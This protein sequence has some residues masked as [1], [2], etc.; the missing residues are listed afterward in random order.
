MYTA[1]RNGTG[2]AVY[3]P[4][5]DQNSPDRLALVG[6]LRR[7]IDE[8]E[9]VLHYQP[10]LDIRTNQVVGVEAL[11][12]W[13]HPE[14]GVLSPGEFIGVAEETG[15]IRPLSLWV[16][17]TALRQAREWQT[18]GY[19]LSVAV[20]LS[21]RNLHD[22]DLPAIVAEHLS[23]VGVAAD[24]LVIEITES[25]L[26]ADP[27]RA[28]N[29]VERL[30]DVGARIAIDDFGTGYSSLSYLTR[31][32]VSELKVDQS[33]V[34]RMLGA[35]NEAAI[36]RSTIGLAHDLGLM[37]VA[38][39]IENAQTLEVLSRLGCDGGQGYHISRPRPADDLT[40]WLSETDGR[41]EVLAAA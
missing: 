3:E 25:T 27:E 38:E 21:M 12:R 15:L 36:V 37:V 40:R 29:I 22:D 5:L 7:A 11:V 23:R 41:D 18:R 33:F 6:E 9:L 4:E 31:L 16:L 19:N 26:M 13:R 17:E 28:L 30:T 8:N 14:R 24:L 10:K 32:P 34:R 1:K 35:T 2:S 20:N 39:G